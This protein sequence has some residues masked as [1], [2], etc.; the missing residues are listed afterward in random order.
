[1]LNGSIPANAFKIDCESKRIEDCLA[2]HSAAAV[3]KRNEINRKGPLAKRREHESRICK[4]PIMKND[5][6]SIEHWESSL[7]TWEKRLNEAKEEVCNWRKKHED[8]EKEK[9]A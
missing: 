3:S 9:E 2:W 7:I 8:L 6:T 4:V 1:M 5:I